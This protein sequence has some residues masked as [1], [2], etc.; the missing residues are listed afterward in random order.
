MLVFGLRTY[1]VPYITTGKLFLVPYLLSNDCRTQSNVK[2]MGKQI[3]IDCMINHSTR[4][5]IEQDLFFFILAQD[6]GGEGFKVH[7][8]VK[9]R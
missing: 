4:S 5:G 8:C 1:T 2:R 7:S 9:L 3:Q 6:W